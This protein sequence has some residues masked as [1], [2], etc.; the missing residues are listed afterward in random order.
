MVK[1]DNDFLTDWEIALDKPIWNSLGDVYER[2]G[3]SQD[4]TAALDEYNS[5]TKYHLLRFKHPMVTGFRGPSLVR[6]LA[7]YLRFFNSEAVRN[8][9]GNEPPRRTFIKEMF[10]DTKT[11]HC[12]VRAVERQLSSGVIEKGTAFSSRVWSTVFWDKLAELQVLTFFCANG[13][14]VE[15]PAR[16]AKG[17][18]PEFFIQAGETK[19]GVEVKNLNCD[20]VLDHVFGDFDFF[21]EQMRNESHWIGGKNVA[22]PKDYRK[23]VGMIERQYKAAAQKFSVKE[24]LIFIY[25]PWDSNVLGKYFE[26]WV[27]T[28]L[29][30]WRNGED[31]RVAGLVFVF[32]RTTIFLENPCNLILKEGLCFDQIS[33]EDIKKTYERCAEYKLW[34]R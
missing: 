8:T 1:L 23:I 13:Y 21:V 34:P 31:L 7:G 33:L 6:R 16:K 18:Q 10:N 11:H 26:K 3:L 19:L 22:L 14:T 32:D 25:V 17:K 12:S 20:V 4:E 9:D 24:G 30:S 27:N 15:L 29:L 5:I 28:L 2:A